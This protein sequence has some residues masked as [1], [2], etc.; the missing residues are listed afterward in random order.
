MET[1]KNNRKKVNQKE[2]KQSPKKT[3]TESTKVEAQN[4]IEDEENL[5]SGVTLPEIPKKKARVKSRK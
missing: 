5:F 2:I 4:D 1:T 3:K